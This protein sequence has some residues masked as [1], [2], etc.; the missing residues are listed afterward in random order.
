MGKL[1][2]WAVFRWVKSAGGSGSDGEKGLVGSADLIKCQRSVV[3]ALLVVDARG[4]G[5]A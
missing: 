4:R 5:G 2:W 1:G 3:V